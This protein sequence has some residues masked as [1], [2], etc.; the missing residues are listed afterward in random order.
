[1]KIY[2][3]ANTPT[4]NVFDTS[5]TNMSYYDR[6]LNEKDL[7]YMQD[8]KNLDGKIVMM[9]PDEY[10]KG[11]AKIF[12]Y[13]YTE[14]Q[15][16]EQ[17]SDSL[18]PQYVDDMKNG[19][20]FPMCFLNYADKGQEGLHRMLAAKIAFGPNVKYPVLVITPYDQDRWD[21][22]EKQKEINDFERYEFKDLIEDMERSLGDWS[23]APPADIA[24]QAKSYI[25]ERSSRRG[26]DITVN[27]E[28]N[29]YQGDKRLDVTLTSYKGLKLEDTSPSNASPWLA[30]MFDMD[31]GASD[32]DIDKMIDDLD[33][34]DLELEDFFLK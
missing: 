17:R 15:L 21:A 5:T 29:E 9:T 34:V 22:W 3:R 23:I 14:K 30:N 18:T 12:G 8:A 1:M 31:R 28:I 2:I 6:F 27:C 10:F 33:Y 16:E 24:D 11:A 13:R 25:E 4:D 26:V 19:D 20:K 32:E 7:K